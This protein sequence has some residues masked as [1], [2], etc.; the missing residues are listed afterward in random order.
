M[1]L[2]LDFEPDPAVEDGWLPEDIF[3]SVLNEN[4]VP[5]DHGRAP[6]RV[7][8]ESLHG[9]AI[10]Q[11][12]I[13]RMTSLLTVHRPKLNYQYVLRWR[14][15]DRTKIPI[16]TELRRRRSKILAIKKLSGSRSWTRS[17]LKSC[18]GRF[19]GR[20]VN[21]NR[22]E[23]I[24]SLLFGYN[25]GSHELPCVATTRSMQ[26]PLAT[27]VFHYGH[28]IVGTAF[29]RRQAI[30]FA[31]SDNRFELFRRLED[32]GLEYLIACPI[33]F[34]NGDGWPIGVITF[35]SREK[36]SHL[37]ECCQIAQLSKQLVQDVSEAFL[38]AFERSVGT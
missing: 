3:F 8:F 21:S 24:I 38:A 25:E 12:G 23:D 13:A 7:I 27:T 11:L 9:K 35:A 31:R 26:D 6:P 29:R 19:F 36:N 37:S 20:L 1:I 34:P 32:D 22:D 17:F 10:T 28:D 18:P 4:K 30:A 2:R 15:P 33:N 14:L 5:V 16:Q